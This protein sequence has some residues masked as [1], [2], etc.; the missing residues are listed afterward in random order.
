MSRGLFPFRVRSGAD[1]HRS[2][3]GC[4]LVRWYDRRTGAELRS[5]FVQRGP[6]G[7]YYHPLPVRLSVHQGSGR[8]DAAGPG[9]VRQGC[10][11]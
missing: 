9:R 8:F 6:G 2:V 11:L 4:L 3:H 10:P 5:G 1:P 7:R